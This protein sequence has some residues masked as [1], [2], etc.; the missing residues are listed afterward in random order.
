MS[1]S[2]LV[3]YVTWNDISVIYVTVQVYRKTEE[4]EPTVGLQTL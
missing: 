3:Y 1:L 2:L 4:V